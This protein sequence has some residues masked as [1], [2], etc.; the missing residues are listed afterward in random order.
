MSLVERSV[1]ALR[2]SISGLTHHLHE[3]SETAVLWQRY[4]K[5]ALTHGLDFLRGD[6]EVPVF[7]P[8]TV[9]LPPWRPVPG[10]SVSSLSKA[11]LVETDDGTM[12]LSGYK[13]GERSG[14]QLLAGDTGSSLPMNKLGADPVG[15][16]S[17]SRWKFDISLHHWLE[18]GIRTD[19]RQYEL[20]MMC[21][22]PVS[23]RVFLWRAPIPAGPPPVR[24]NTIAAGPYA[25]LSVERDADAETIRQSYM[26]L[27]KEQ[28]P[29]LGGSEDRFKALSKAYALLADPKRRARY[30]L[31][32]PEGGDE[33]AAETEELGE[34][35]SIKMPFT[36]FK[37]RSIFD[38]GE[39][40][41]HLFILLDEER[42][43]PF[44]LEL[45]EIV[46]GRCE[47]GALPAAGFPGNV[48]CS[49]GHCECGYYDGWRVEGFEG[50]LEQ[51]PAPKG[52][53]EFGFAH[54]HG[55]IKETT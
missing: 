13:S 28:H 32:G 46:L 39:K 2:K 53:V 4:R 27:A 22:S 29:D 38:Y 47:K 6:A 31:F 26:Q 55:H 14:V 19:G 18:L 7:E 37:D 52:A 23:S 11:T 15:M 34:W 48:G 49:M 41:D 9:G 1:N 40:V 21:E 50:P 51:V 25:I 12:L 35:R 43:G 3:V 8:H 54:H 24:R 10:P 33:A 45:G 20:V 17:T 36:A 44:R 42:E 5:N 16:A 30:D